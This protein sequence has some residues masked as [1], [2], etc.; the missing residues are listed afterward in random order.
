[1]I[2]II[3]SILMGYIGVSIGGFIGSD[4]T[5]YL[6]GVVGFFSPSLYVLEKLYKEM[7]NKS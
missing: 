1:M 6:F 5:M 2:L 4:M 3:L 7:N